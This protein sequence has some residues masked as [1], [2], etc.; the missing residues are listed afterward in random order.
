MTATKA[1]KSR[2]NAS[3]RVRGSA[4]VRSYQSTGKELQKR[5]P[6]GPA[7]AAACAYICVGLMLPDEVEV[8]FGQWYERRNWRGDHQNMEFRKSLSSTEPKLS[9]ATSSGFLRRNLLDLEKNIIFLPL[10]LSWNSIRGNLSKVSGREAPAPAIGF[11]IS[12]VYS[13][14]IRLNSSPWFHGK[15]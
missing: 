13:T 14:N 11:L 12:T 15:R 10:G 1:P 5:V 6:V 2:E 3:V 7:W 4:R 9:N 8:Y